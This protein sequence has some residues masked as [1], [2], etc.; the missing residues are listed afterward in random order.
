[1]RSRIGSDKAENVVIFMCVY[2]HIG[3]YNRQA[4]KY[5]TQVRDAFSPLAYILG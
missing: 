2:I 5:L 1:M 4:G 3:G